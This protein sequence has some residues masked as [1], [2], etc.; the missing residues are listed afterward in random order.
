VKTSPS[1]VVDA[2]LVSSDSDMPVQSGEFQLLAAFLP[3]VLKEFNRIQIE[4]Q[5]D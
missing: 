1:L 4:Q 5:K 3:E 2:Q